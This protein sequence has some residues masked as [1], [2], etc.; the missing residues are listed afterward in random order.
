MGLGLLHGDVQNVS[1]KTTFKRGCH[2][3]CLSKSILQYNGSIQK[4]FGSVTSLMAMGAAKWYDLTFRA[5]IQP[6]YIS[7][8]VGTGRSESNGIIILLGRRA[9]G[10]FIVYTIYCIHFGL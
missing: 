10:K 4:V 7:T 9:A 3:T 8:G 5:I 2:D 6:V 1:V